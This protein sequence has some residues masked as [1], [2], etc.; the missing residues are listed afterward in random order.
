MKIKV[1]DNFG[2][3]LESFGKSYAAINDKAIE[4]LERFFEEGLGTDHPRMKY[5][6]TKDAYSFRVLGNNAPGGPRVVM[7]KANDD[8]FV[9]IF[10][11]KHSDYDRY[12]RGN[13][14][15]LQIEEVQ[16]GKRLVDLETDNYK[17]SVETVVELEPVPR[18]RLEF[19]QFSTPEEGRYITCKSAN[20][21]FSEAQLAVFESVSFEMDTTS[22]DDAAVKMAME[23]LKT[24]K[25]I[26]MESKPSELKDGVETFQMVYHEVGQNSETRSKVFDHLGVKQDWS[27]SNN[28]DDCDEH[29]NG[30]TLTTNGH[31]DSFEQT[32]LLMADFQERS[33]DGVFADHV[34]AASIG[35]ELLDDSEVAEYEEMPSGVS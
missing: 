24:A 4:S 7:A 26:V 6:M 21:Y 27:S 1:R 2:D 33:E 15:E 25:S 12:L 13:K 3:L 23:D 29:I 35:V 8:Q 16:A 32:I 14:I 31:G 9:P 20:L 34:L 18:D 11:G 10:I 22:I 5:L 28:Y 30:D 19:T 17:K